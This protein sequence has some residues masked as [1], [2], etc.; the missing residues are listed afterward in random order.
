MDLY[1]LLGVEREASEAEVRRAY[2]KR[3]RALH[4]HLNPGDP[5]AAQR[6]E[7]VSAAF[8]VLSDP[9]R[10]AAYDRGERTEVARPAAQGSFDGFDFSAEVRVERVGFREIFDAALQPQAAIDPARGEDL[11]QRTRLTFEESLRGTERRLLVERYEACPACQGAGELAATPAPCPRCHGTGQMRGRRGHMLFSRRCGACD[12]TGA[13]RRRACASCSA[14]GRV[15]GSEQ[16]DVRIPPGARSGSAVRLAGC[17]HSGRRGGP[18]GDLL[19][20]IDVEEHPVFRREG[21]DLQCAVPVSIVEA[22]L[23]SHVEVETPDGPVTIELP[24]GTQN[25]QR[26]RLRKRGMPRLGD[27]VR[28]DL[29]AEV[30]VSVPTVTDDVGREQL[31]AFALAH[32]Q[33]REALKAALEAEEGA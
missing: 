26:F 17:G 24:A 32:P 11:E 28:G 22:A 4:P 23:G 7:E 31:K 6:F 12:G 13:L 18:P 5:E 9:K 30:R 19:L 1:E 20:H 15:P 8:G 27:G 14:E 29:Y 33:T 16:L 2:Q 10:R 21:D 25:G 3:A